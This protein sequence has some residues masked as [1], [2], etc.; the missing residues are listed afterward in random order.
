[1][2]KLIRIIFCSHIKYIKT[3]KVLGR[4]HEYKCKKCGKSIYRDYFNPPI[5]LIEK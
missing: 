5:S 3:G 2:K 1:M 4:L